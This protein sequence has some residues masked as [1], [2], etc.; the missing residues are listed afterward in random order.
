MAVIQAA[1]DRDQNRVPVSG[2]DLFKTR[3]TVTF[4]GATGAGAVEAL[5][6]FQVTG[7]VVVDLIVP[8]ITGTLTSGGAA[9]IGLGAVGN[10]Q[11][12][13]APTAYSNLAAN[14]IW[15][16]DTSHGN[17]GADLNNINGVRNHITRQNILLDILVAAITG[18]SMEITAFW[19]PVTSDGQL[20]AL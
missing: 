16:S 10:G 15:L 2:V 19:R 18:G 6:I 9:T 5:Q 12:F 20:I 3:K 17:T 13:I 1:L 8:Y 7:V 11:F 14:D 4:T